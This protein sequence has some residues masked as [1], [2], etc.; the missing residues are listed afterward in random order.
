MW[1]ERL[2]DVRWLHINKDLVYRKICSCNKNVGLRKNLVE[3][4]CKVKGKWPNEVTRLVQVL[5][6]IT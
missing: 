1:T 4:L 2:I 6:D 5:D 3:F